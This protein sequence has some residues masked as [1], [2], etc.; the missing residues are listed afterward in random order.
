VGSRAVIIIAAM[1]A[2]AVALAGKPYTREDL[3]AL[4]KSESWA[5]LVDHATDLAPAGRDAAWEAL[6]LP[7]AKHVLEAAPASEVLATLERL[8]TR[9]PFLKKAAD[10]QALR[11]ERGLAALQACF[12]ASKTGADCLEKIEPLAGGNSALTFK[13]AKVA[14][15]SQFAYVPVTL[16][17][18]ALENASTPAQC[19]DDELGRCVKA[20]LALPHGEPRAADARSLLGGRCSKELIDFVEAD[21]HDAKPGSEF[22]RN[23]CP[24]FKKAQALKSP[25]P[26]GG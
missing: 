21:L 6:V 26:C 5:E 8:T 19:E 22:A 18:K 13:A 24:A 3:Q 4:S 1:L 23:A 2:S 9:F 11:E 14:M 7:A 15:R 12:E 16:F 10:F 17:R 20:A 25:N